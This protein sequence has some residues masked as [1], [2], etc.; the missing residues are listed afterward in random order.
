MSD[1][2]PTPPHDPNPP[3]EVLPY[4][5]PPPMGLPVGVQALLGTIATGAGAVVSTIVFAFL[6]GMTSDSK[7]LCTVMT[8]VCVAVGLGELVAVIRLAIRLRRTETKR[9]WAIGIWI[10]L[11]LYALFWGTCGL[12]LYN[13][14]V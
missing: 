2:P 9:G 7:P 1:L 13:L 4:R 12:L 8:I 5:V 10:G 14:E 3:H 6:I 11:G